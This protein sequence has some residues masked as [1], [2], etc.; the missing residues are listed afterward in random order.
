MKF[1]PKSAWS[2]IFSQF[3]STAIR[4]SGGIFWGKV[5]FFF[6]K[7][8]FAHLFWSLGIFVYLLTKKSGYQG[9]NLL[10]RKKMEEKFVEKSIFLNHF[11]TP[12]R[13]FWRNRQILPAGLW[14]LIS[15]CSEKQFQDISLEWR[16]FAQIFC[17]LSGIVGLLVWIYCQFSQNC[18]LRLQRNVL[19]FF[20]ERRVI[21]WSFSVSERK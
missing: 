14:K 17:N 13:K 12:S 15:K 19:T 8:I 4:A 21:F 7:V 20:L 6:K 16:N 2:V 10:I 11:R 3:V 1:D 18:S 5:I 9:S